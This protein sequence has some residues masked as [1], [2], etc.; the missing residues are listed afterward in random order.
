MS[1]WLSAAL[2]GYSSDPS[3][4]EDSWELSQVGLEVQIKASEAKGIRSH[5]KGW[6]KK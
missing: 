4:C 1:K 6:R 5:I 2:A 3:G